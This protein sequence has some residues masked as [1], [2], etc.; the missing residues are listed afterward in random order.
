[1][2][3]FNPLLFNSWKFWLGIVLIGV[4]SLFV[5][6]YFV[7]ETRGAK[8]K[9]EL[10]TNYI[11]AI[12]QEDT[13]QIVSLT[14]RSHVVSQSELHD[15]LVKTGG[16]KLERVQVSSL[17]S[18]SPQLEIVKLSGA[19][20]KNG[21]WLEFTDLLYLQRINQRWYLLLGRDK[22]GLPVDAPSLEFD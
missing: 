12:R 10:I 18:E 19:F 3:I 17:P 7:V 2:S 13:N 8:T 5:V 20:A 6:R 9:E 16:K 15:I 1:M 22:N 11:L 21:E 14:P 4:L